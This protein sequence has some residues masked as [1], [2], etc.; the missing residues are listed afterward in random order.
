M[1]IY[2]IVVSIFAGIL[3][4]GCSQKEYREL[5]QYTIEQFLNTTTLFGSSF[6][7]DEQRILFTSDRS[8]VFN[9]YTIAVE[10]G[11]P[12]QL[13]FSDSTSFIA[14][15]FF[16]NDNRILLRSDNNGDEIW[17]IFL[18][19]EDGSIRDLTPYPGARALFFRWSRDEQSFFFTSN[20]RDSRYMDIYEMDLNTFQPVMVYQNDEGFLLGAI[21][22]NERYLAFTKPI[23]T[24]NTELY[25]YDRQNRQLKYLSPHEGDVKYFPVT[26]SVDSRQLY[27]LTD[28][29]SEFTYLRRY[30]ISNGQTETVEKADWDILYAYFSHKGR[31]RVLGVNND[32]RT[33]IRIY[34]TETGKPV[35]LPRL[36]NADISS[37]HISKSEKLMTFYVNGSRSPNNL[38]VFDLETRRYKKL[39]ESLNP[40]IDPD[41]LVDARVVRYPSFDGLKIPALLYKPHQIKPGEKAPAIVWV[42]GGPGGQSRIRYSAL[43]QFLVNHGYVVL[44]VNNRGSSGYGK[45]FYKL[46]DLKH[47]EDDLMDCVTAKNFLA[48]TGFTDTSRVAILGGSY[49]GYMVLAALTFR[50]TAFAAGV[51]LF[52]ISNWVRTLKS[53]PPWWEAYREA[54]YQEMGDPEK[55][56]EYLYSISPLFHAE[57]I[58]RP[59]LVLQG[60]ND[61]R[62]LKTESDEIVE[63]VR[64]NGVPVE[65]ILFED[66]G[67][68]FRKKENQIKGYKAILQFLEK[69]LK[70]GAGKTLSQENTSDE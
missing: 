52:G 51:D 45:T 17:H 36:P 23:T 32:A 37:V 3:L 49:G 5:P 12:Q 24:H 14:I 57:N 40:E 69:Y 28:E 41:N 25:L 58:R 15:S 43:I 18:R 9:A 38:F 44:A 42:H 65:Y 62:V 63:A 19:E 8:G 1:R 54:L 64:K 33:E 48:S 4:W 7:P 35:N 50:P 59:L 68:G 47:G 21:S 29:G 13:T 70:T 61:P 27:Y 20:K 67:H 11:E 39:T 55:D 60:A 66:E 30:D 34:D 6:S 26:F 16:P 31:Y 10:G 56:E 22:N 2:Q 46:D 53:I